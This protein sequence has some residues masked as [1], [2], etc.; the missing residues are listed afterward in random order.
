VQ[1]AWDV[2]LREKRDETK[3]TA[4]LTYDKIMKAKLSKLP[5]DG[6]EI[7]ESHKSATDES[8]TIF[9]EVTLGNSTEH[10]LMALKEL[11]VRRIAQCFD[12]LA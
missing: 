5:C 9:R 11:M 2:F 7:L 8:R 6:D 4:L 10:T 1:T 3:K 12:C